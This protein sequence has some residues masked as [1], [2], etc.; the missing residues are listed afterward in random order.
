MNSTQ[1][2]LSYN[3]AKKKKKENKLVGFFR[4]RFRPG[5]T[6]VFIRFDGNFFVILL[7]QPQ[8]SRCWPEKKTNGKGNTTFGR[9]SNLN[10]NVVARSNN[11]YVLQTAKTN[12]HS[13]NVFMQFVERCLLVFFVVES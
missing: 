10:D 8:Y 3:T 6:N 7:F 2:R 9:Q 4:L 13:T 5:K 1:G 12:E 11:N